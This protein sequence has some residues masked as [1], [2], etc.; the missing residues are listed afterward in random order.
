M[1]LARSTWR[2][3]L[4]ITIT[5][6]AW[7]APAPARRPNV[8]FI[9]ADDLGYAE[10]GCYGQEKIRTPHIDRMAA[11]GMR[12]T[13]HYC[14][15]PVCATS[16]CV[17]MTGKHSGHAHVRNNREMK[18]LRKSTNEIPTV[19]GGQEPIPDEEITIA[20]LFQQ[21]GYATAAFGKWGLGGVET[22]GDPLSQGF[23]RFFGYNCQRHA[24]N[25]YPYYLVDDRDTR[26]LA[27][28]TRE[29]VGE[30]YAPDLYADEALKFIREHKDKPFFVYFPT[31]VPHLA[32]QVP[33]DSLAE[34]KGL[35]EDPP[36]EGGHG[37]LPHPAP[38]AA[39]AAMVTRMD[40]D[41]G[42]MM[43]LVAELGL[44]DETIFVFTSD[45]GPT[46][47]RLGGSDSD[48]FGSAGPLRGLKGSIYEGGI[49]VP[50]VVRWPGK[51][52]A[53]SE[54]DLPTA[55]YDWMPTLMDL[56]GAAESIP[57]TTDG[58]SFSPTLLGRPEEQKRQEYLVWEFTGYGGQQAVRMGD[59]KGV[60]QNL[61]PRGKNAGTPRLDIELYN[62]KTDIGETTNVATEH[63]EIVARIEQIMRDE[64]TVSREFPLPA[65]DQLVVQ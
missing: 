6:F 62:L 34:Y 16:R 51:V 41:V 19:Y 22:T 26:L 32:L 56:I 20:E 11:E 61:L 48:F 40:R 52:P 37:Y 64:H 36:Y 55:F 17:L 5:L 12:L 49:R 21:N 45:N 28:N 15:N 43:D 9:I 65:L 30:Q 39:Y 63:P 8:V 13:D 24:H 59:W 4:T 23:D 46:Y 7:S 53:G 1:H 35:W 38:R 29:L 44:D 27:G 18:N 50:C 47:D 57:G 58:V 2:I 10:L 25:F 42:R 60:R 14:G 31:I 33:N 3:A 54:S